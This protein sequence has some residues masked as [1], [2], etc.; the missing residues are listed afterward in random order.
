M[1]MPK[2]LYDLLKTSLKDADKYNDESLFKVVTDHYSKMEKAETDKGE[3][4]KKR[5]KIKEDKKELETKLEEINGAIE[6]LKADN[7]KLTKNQKTD[8]DKKVIDEGISEE[9][10]AK[11]NAINETLES[12]KTSLET[13]RTEKQKALE[14]AKETG[15]STAKTNLQSELVKSLAKYKITGEKCDDAIAIID[16]LGLAKVEENEGKYKRSFIVHKE[17]GPVDLKDAEGVAKLISETR[18]Y[19]VDSSGN[20]GTGNKPGKNTNMYTHDGET[21]YTKAA[22]DSENRL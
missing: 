20:G 8:K 10:L 6:T 9:W 5:D 2:E 14:K 15:L 11:F 1:A 22:R 21:D 4:I 16:R 3:V 7:E 18:E 19:L 13:E 17:T 12:V